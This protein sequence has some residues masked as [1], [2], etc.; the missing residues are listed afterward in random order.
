MP[1]QS[2]SAVLA[3]IATMV[4]WGTSAVF[5]R[6]TAL[7]LS[8]ENALALRYVLLVLIFGISLLRTGQWRIARVDWPRIAIAALAML[9]SSWFT[10]QGFARVAAGVGALVQMV[11]PIIIAL[12]AALLLAERPA[13]RIWTGLAVSVM[14]GLVLF[15]PDISAAASTPVDPWGLVA[16]IA[17][18]TCFA[19]YTIAA[20]PLA[21]RYSGFTV[22]AW[23][24][25]LSSPIVFLLASR[26]YGELLTATPAATWFEILYLAVFNSILG[27][28][29]WTYGSSRLAGASAGSF[30][31]LMPV[32]A[33]VA[34]YLWLGEPITAFIVIGGLVMLAGVA[35]AQSRVTR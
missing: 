10:M 5:L 22:T 20:K 2:H 3:L 6:T 28:V 23:A 34:G 24:M 33:V 30:L 32:V 26:P 7:A 27:N 8:A 11:E 1:A 15:W 21:A 13:G 4:I 12:L 19:A 25:L 29:L 14:G 35:I 16:L 18:S 31:Y 9:G 17:A